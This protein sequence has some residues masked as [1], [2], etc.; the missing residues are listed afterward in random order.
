MLRTPDG[1]AAVAIQRRRH[2]RGHLTGLSA[3]A[4]QSRIEPITAVIEDQCTMGT[5]ERC[6]QCEWCRL[7]TRAKQALEHFLHR[8]QAH[9]GWCSL[10]D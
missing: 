9:W 4:A 8:G 7:H 2:Q 3:G 6:E 5:H 1:L 10:R